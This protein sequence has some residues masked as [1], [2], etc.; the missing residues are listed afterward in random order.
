MFYLY[1]KENEIITIIMAREDIR[2]ASKGIKL[3]EKNC[4]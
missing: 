1:I 3:E 4:Q 2:G